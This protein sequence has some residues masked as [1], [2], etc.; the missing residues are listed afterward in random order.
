M[1]YIDLESR[2]LS[3][4]KYHNETFLLVISPTNGCGCW[5]NFQPVLREF[6]SST[7]YHVYEI[8]ITEFDENAKFG[9]NMK[10]GTVSFAIIKEVNFLGANPEIETIGDYAFKDCMNAS[11]SIQIP[12]S[13]KSIG[14]EAFSCC[15]N[16]TSVT[17]AQG[18]QLEVIGDCAFDF[19]ESLTSITIP[20]SV[21][22]IGHQAFG[23]CANLNYIR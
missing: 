23:Y 8:K 12:A 20:N 4:G 9:L 3:T 21:T 16:I 15:R 10:Q 17:F 2:M 6:M 7:K 11:F 18:S 22:S 5:T 1:E 14:Y 13:V 19:C